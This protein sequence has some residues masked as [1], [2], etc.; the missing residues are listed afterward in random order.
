[1]ARLATGKNYKNAA[2][3]LH[4]YLHSSGR[5]FPV[6]ISSARIPLRHSRRG[7][8]E[9]M[10]NYPV[11]LLSS[12]LQAVLQ[13]GGEFVLGG[14]TTRQRPQYMSM[15]G[16][17]WARYRT[18]HSS[19]PVLAKNDE[20]KKRT[21]PIAIHGDEGRGTCKEP[22]L[23]ESFQPIVPWTGENCLNMR[24]RFEFRFI[25]HLYDLL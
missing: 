6:Q 23:V 17:F 21:I 3:H 12:W 14:W 10:A 13:H 22:V 24:G 25:K 7:G 20:Q 4:Q 11:I 8:G 9:F 2:H 1:M 5:T 16:R 18:V 19:H 15:L